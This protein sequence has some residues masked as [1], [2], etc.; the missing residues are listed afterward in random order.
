MY[1]CEAW[2]LLGDDKKRKSMEYS[3]VSTAFNTVSESF[4]LDL[5]RQ[6]IALVLRRDPRPPLR[7]PPP[8]PPPSL[9]KNSSHEK[10][11]RTVRSDNS[12]VG[13]ITFDYLRDAEHRLDAKITHTPGERAKPCSEQPS[14]M[15]GLCTIKISSLAAKKD[16]SWRDLAILA[17][18]VPIPRSR[19][20]RAIRA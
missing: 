9:I 15:L 19:T 14:V 17:A 2:R 5:R 1:T 20:S 4:L 13:I 6:G 16:K 7:T 10:C 12:R 8:S 3:M 11:Q 18:K